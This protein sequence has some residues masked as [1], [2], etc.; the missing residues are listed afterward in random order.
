MSQVRGPLR[1]ASRCRTLRPHRHDQA[2]TSCPGQK[3]SAVQPWI[4]GIEESKS[5]VLRGIVERN[6]ALQMH[7]WLVPKSPMYSKRNPEQ[8]GGRSPGRRRSGL[9]LAQPQQLLGDPA[10]KNQLARASRAPPTARTVPGTA[11]RSHRRTDTIRGPVHKPGWSPVRVSLSSAINAT[12]RAI[13]R[14]SSCRSRSGPSGRT[15]SVSSPLVRR[16]TASAQHRARD[17]LTP[18]LVPVVDCLLDETRL[19]CNGAR[20][21]RVVPPPAP[22]TG[23]PA[24]ARCEHAGAG[25]GTSS[26]VP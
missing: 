17:R 9:L 6:R 12:P 20:E 23:P 11:A 1:A 26:R 7:A 13:C 19:R 10:R 16:A 5:A 4:L 3:A 24:P 15:R 14:S 22:E 18:R 21:A 25:D 2:T 8:H